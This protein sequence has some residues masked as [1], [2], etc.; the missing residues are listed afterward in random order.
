MLTPEPLDHDADSLT[1]IPPQIHHWVRAVVIFGFLSFVTSVTLLFLLIYRLIQWQIKSKRTNQFVILIFNLVWADIQQ[2][3]A[4]VLNIEWLRMDSVNIASPICWAQ[5]WFV[6][7]GDLASGVWCFTIGLHTFASVILNYRLPPRYFF[8]TVA[9]LWIFIY[10]MSAIPALLYGKN[11]YVRAGTWC[12]IHHNLNDLRLWTHYFWIFLF[13]FGN[14]IIYAVIYAML[15]QRIR[16]GYYTAMEAERVKAISNLMVVYPIVYVIC[17]LPL[18]SA[19]M[20]SM[21]GHPP[22]LARLCLAGAMITS[23]GWLDVLLYT[24]TRR[25]MV[26]SDEPPADDNGLDTFS[27][28]WAESPRRFGAATTIEA[29]GCPSSAREK[30]K[31][32][33]TRAGRGLVTLPAKS[34]SSD[35]LCGSKDIKLVTT[36]HVTSEPAQPADYLEM[37]AEARRKR[38][39]TPVGRWSEESGNLK[40]FQLERIPD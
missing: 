5:G 31:P 25:I 13:E 24:L 33:R 28:F 26:F 4:F 6:S 34:E 7:T 14:V 22:S 16:S 12:W 37:E 9:M 20:A 10:G 40:E 35:D 23:N 11:L 3:L 8:L 19:R 15:L 36:T 38:P 32:K 39:R 29:V 2:S 17:T 1:P 30:Q 18:A 27:A 21:S